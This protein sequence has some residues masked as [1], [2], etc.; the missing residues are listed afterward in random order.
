MNMLTSLKALLFSSAAAQMPAEGAAAPAE[1]AIDFAAL[2]SGTMEAAP[3]ASQATELGGVPQATVPAPAADAAQG[4]GTEIASAGAEHAMGEAPKPSPL[5]FGLATAL[6]AVQS[7]RRESLPLPPGLAKKIEISGEPA[8][9]KPVTDGVA[10]EK[11]E[12]DTPPALANESSE[13]E[14]PEQP[15]VTMQEQPRLA[16]RIKQAKPPP[17]E[18]VFDPIAQE[19]PV[20]SVKAPQADEDKPQEDVA[21]APFS[22]PS[23]A[24]VQTQAPPTAP[25]PLPASATP[26]PRKDGVLATADGGKNLPAP[27]QPL[28]QAAAQPHAGDSKA[29]AA[30]PGS[31]TP[32]PLKTNMADAASSAAD[33]PVMVEGEG[34][35]RPM[36][37]EAL[38]LLQLVRD[39]VAPRQPG[40]P[41]RA[42]KPL[43]RAK[44]GH[45]TPAAEIMPASTRPVPTEAAPPAPVAQVAAASS[46]Q[47][48]GTAPPTVDLSAS[49]GA[50][51]VDMGVSGQWIDGLT[52]DIAG[53]SANGAQGRFQINA[54]Q[55]GPVQ[56]DIRQGTDGAAVSL[57]VASEAAELALRQDS[58]RLKLDAGLAAVRI[59]EVKVERAPHAAE[60][61][62]ADSPSQQSSQQQTSQQ[63]PGQSGWANGQN[64][65]QSQGQGQGRWQGR[66]NSPFPAKEPGNPAVLNHDDRRPATDGSARARYA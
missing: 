23:I 10:V 64:M 7:H 26:S 32:D 42:G 15:A 41:V 22:P 39:Q 55:L 29:E 11:G 60:A 28:P 62:R 38:A 17:V 43:D 4:G 54:D 45:A 37:S 47:P 61:A 9:T 51:L 33:L 46:V 8:Q 6:Q 20:E 30:I 49:I 58:D 36:K 3:Q 24:A 35:R 63:Q 52:R 40:T 56:V 48:T 31:A 59:A 19:Q 5:P 53:L 50:Q 21:D 44:A 18:A 1:G 16:H 2:L 13:A 57:T 25:A 27:A 65:S 66:E 34:E 14:V 12:A